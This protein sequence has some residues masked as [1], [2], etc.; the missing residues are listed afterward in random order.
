MGR[1][2]R[3]LF[4]WIVALSLILCITTI[5]VWIRSYFAA[6]WITFGKIHDP[7]CDE[8]FYEF[9]SDSGN[10]LFNRIHVTVIGPAPD[11]F[12]V[13]K[14]AGMT[15]TPGFSH[16]SKP[17]EKVSSKSLREY[18]GADYYG[19]N[20]QRQFDGDPD[21]R[22][23]SPGQIIESVVGSEIPHWYLVVIFSIVPTWYFLRLARDRR[24]KR[25][26]SCLNC[27]YDLRATPDRCPE[28]GTVPAK[29]EI[30]SR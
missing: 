23:P 1:F 21:H 24:R 17:P 13:Y 5:V 19:S 9:N 11:S 26:N 4:S 25:T 22:F 30:I 7:K 14:D 27:G 8:S 29:R 12:Q 6:D 3:W 15:L 18:V 16:L 28:C 2:R 10:L 20:T